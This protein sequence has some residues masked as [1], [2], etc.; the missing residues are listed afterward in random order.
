METTGGQ[1]RVSFDSDLNKDSVPGAVS[2]KGVTTQATY[3]PHTRTVV[4]T[5]PGGLTPGQTYYLQVASSLQ[6]VSRRTAQSY[7]LPFNGPAS[8]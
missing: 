5:A 1:V 4:L 2:V 3:D 7:E 8:S 6:D